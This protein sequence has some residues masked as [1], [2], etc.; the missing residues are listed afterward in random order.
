M[1]HAPFTGFPLGL[2][3][4]LE[5]LSRHNTKQWFDANRERY[6]TELRQPALQFIEAMEQPLKKISPHLTAV[7]KKV[8]G[9]LMRIHRDTRFSNDKS[10]YKTNVGIQFRHETGKDVHCP[11]YYFHIDTDQVFLAA[12]IW[13]PDNTTLR[14]IRETIDE[15]PSDWKRARDGKAFRQRFELSGD[16]LKRPPRGFGTDHKYV[17]DL[18]RKDHI[19]VANLDY[20]LLFDKNLA[21]IATDHYR[22]AK[23]YMKFLCEAIDV[24]W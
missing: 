18:K 2:L 22:A 7:P 15:Y 19:A 9:S 10:P 20:D 5:E 13:H 6:E 16:S 17:D 11:G 14:A 4:F 3:H 24:A 12:G 23:G 21:R 8:G 1:S